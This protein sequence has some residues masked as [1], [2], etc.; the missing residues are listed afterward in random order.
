MKSNQINFFVLPNDLIVFEKILLNHG[1]LFI[2]QPI[3]DLNNLYSNSI[4]YLPDEN[5]FDKIFLTTKE[6][7]KNIVIEKVEKQP[8]YLINGLLSEVVEFSR[9][10]LLYSNNKLERGRFYYVNSYYANN[11]T[12]RKSLEFEKWANS[13]LQLLERKFCSKTTLKVYII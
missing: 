12:I 11:L 8:Y 4:Q 9:G 5:L 7:Q 6:F 13:I 3:Y 1:A 2:K 10:G